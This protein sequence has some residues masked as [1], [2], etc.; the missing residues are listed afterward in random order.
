M[1]MITIPQS[2][3]DI[4]RNTQKNLLSLEPGILPSSDSF[5][6]ALQLW[7]TRSTQFTSSDIYSR[8]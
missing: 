1:K 4:F 8:L 3:I 6:R 5:L 7:V 2:A